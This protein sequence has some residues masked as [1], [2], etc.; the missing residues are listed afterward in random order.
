MR[1][2]TN[3]IKNT[4]SSS[5][6][7][8]ITT[9][10]QVKPQPQ[11]VKSS[12]SQPQSQSVK[13]QPQKRKV[14]VTVDKK[15]DNF[16]LNK[17]SVLTITQEEHS[18]LAPL[19]ACVPSLTTY[20]A[21]LFDP[22]CT[23]ET[24]SRLLIYKGSMRGDY[25][26][27]V[28]DNKLLSV[29]LWSPDKNAKQPK[30]KYIQ[31]NLDEIDAYYEIPKGKQSAFK[32][33]Y[34]NTSEKDS[35]TN[36]A[37][38]TEVN[39]PEIEEPEQEKEENEQ[40]EQEQ[41]KEELKN[42]TAPTQ[43]NTSPYPLVDS[44]KKWLT[45]CYLV[46]YLFYSCPN[47]VNYY[48]GQ[49]FASIMT[50]RGVMSKDFDSN[51]EIEDGKIEI[52]SDPIS[53]IPPITKSY[54][55]VT[56]KPYV[57]PKDSISQ[58]KTKTEYSLYLLHSILIPIIPRLLD[59]KNEIQSTFLQNL[60][61]KYNITKENISEQ[62]ISTIKAFYSQ[63]NKEFYDPADVTIMNQI[64]KLD[65]FTENVKIVKVDVKKIINKEIDE[66]L[67]N[68]YRGVKEVK[69]SRKA[70]DKK[71]ISQEH[72]DVVAFPIPDK[73]TLKDLLAYAST[74]PDYKPS[75][76]LRS[77]LNSKLKG[78]YECD[79]NYAED[80]SKIA[81]SKA[82]AKYKEDTGKKQK[83]GKTQQITGTMVRTPKKSSSLAPQLKEEELNE[84]L[85][86]NDNVNE[87]EDIYPGNEDSE[88]PELEGGN[89]EQEEQ[90][91]QFN[92]ED[93]GDQDE[94]DI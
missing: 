66:E 2:Y 18:S 37:N 45:V 35:E 67:M 6:Q 9:R 88:V 22:H 77:A 29:K 34:S 26:L 43:F 74:L 20:V 5:I 61:K 38:E 42:K 36:E 64:L 39:D 54:E 1:S 82:F 41:E 17:K 80:L 12:K 11:L 58:P 90:E 76:S 8:P 78:A 46:P 72:F 94:L 85:K 24:A 79:R 53:S 7:K 93:E 40:E 65:K 69:P 60:M 32:R 49:L 4:S 55:P 71:Y 84:D 21:N 19:I 57:K 48:S 56:L 3:K 44:S 14:N 62:K 68:E 70:S 47:F 51:A 63:L 89:E 27:M 25:D 83:P 16:Q 86:V 30:D 91:E 59:R 33:L 81:N 50:E 23:I 13:R 52:E 87:D 28:F 92:Q 31:V 75:T 10:Q 73:T 15:A